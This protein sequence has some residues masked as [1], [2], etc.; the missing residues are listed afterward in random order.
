MPI[1]RIRSWSSASSFE[2]MM[3]APC[4]STSG[5]AAHGS[6]LIAAEEKCFVGDGEEDDA[7]PPPPPEAVPFPFVLRLVFSKPLDA[8]IPLVAA[9]T[10]AAGGGLPVDDDSV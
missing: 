9:P 5:T 6:R 1:C 4:S 2:R 7:P 3:E 10:V 8:K